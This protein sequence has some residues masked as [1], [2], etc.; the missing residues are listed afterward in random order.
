MRQRRRSSLI[1]VMLAAAFSLLVP[2]AIAPSAQAVTYVCSGTGYPSRTF[3]V[4]YGSVNSTWQGY[5]DTARN[6][7]NNSGAG[8]SIGKSSSAAASMN[9][10]SYSAD[11]LGLYTPTWVV[12]ITSFNIKVN[13]R[14]LSLSAGSNFAAWAMSTATHELGHALRLNDNPA[15]SSVSLMKH[16]RDR[17]AVGAASGY[18]VAN[19]KACY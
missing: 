10:G 8:A 3:N 13:T 14:T 9:A 17:V 15:T 7:W 18:D 19:V 4:K 5:F 12:Q 16:S 1:T 2:M 11:W 6:R